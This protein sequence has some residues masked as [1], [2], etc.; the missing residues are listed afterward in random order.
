MEPLKSVNQHWAVLLVEDILAYLNDV[1]CPDSNQVRVE[2]GVMQSAQC[3]PIRHRRH[4]ERICIGEDMR[5][6]EQFVAPQPAHGT[7]VLVGAH[8]ALAKFTLV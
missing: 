2:R 8:H 5:G 7:M 1:V 4:A 6:F 3:K